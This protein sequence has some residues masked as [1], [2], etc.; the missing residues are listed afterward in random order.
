MAG[1]NPIASAKVQTG[2]KTGTGKAPTSA[3]TQT[4]TTNPN[5]SAGGGVPKPTT[6]APATPKAPTGGKASRK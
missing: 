6:G 3:R 1:K 4:T 5:K 2:V